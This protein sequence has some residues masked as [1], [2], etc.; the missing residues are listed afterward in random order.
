MHLITEFKIHEIKQTKGEIDNSTVIV[1]D[2]NTPPPP[3]P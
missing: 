3:P 1:G 2:F